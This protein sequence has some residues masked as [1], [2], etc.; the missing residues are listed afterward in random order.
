M[1]NSNLT[2]TSVRFEHWRAPVM[3]ETFSLNVRLAPVMTKMFESSKASVMKERCD[4][5]V[6]MF[7]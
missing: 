1:F 6:G 3:A 2:Y 5:N 4:L 7:L